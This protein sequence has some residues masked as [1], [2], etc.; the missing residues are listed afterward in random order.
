MG[1]LSRAR[2]VVYLLGNTGPNFLAKRLI[3]AT[4]NWKKYQFLWI[5]ITK[6]IKI[7]SKNI[8]L[9]RSQILGGGGPQNYCTLISDFM[10]VEPACIIGNGPN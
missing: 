10:G 5:D 1:V 3:F 2:K 9:L 8:N 4:E 6:L 7:N